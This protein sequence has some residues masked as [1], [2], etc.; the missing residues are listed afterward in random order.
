MNQ[1]I[2]EI[3]LTFNY[4][5]NKFAELIGLREINESV[6]ITLGLKKKNIYNIVKI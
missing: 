5:G 1:T 3:N 6:L 4:L 2:Q